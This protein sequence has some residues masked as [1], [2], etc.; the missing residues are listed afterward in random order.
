MEQ[1]KYAIEPPVRVDHSMRSSIM[2]LL[3][4]RKRHSC[5]L[6]TRYLVVYT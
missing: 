3:C 1:E 5:G 6:P 4:S 2:S